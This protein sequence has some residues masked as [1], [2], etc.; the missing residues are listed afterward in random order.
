MDNLQEQVKSFKFYAVRNKFGKWFRG[1]GGYGETWVDELNQA[2]IYNKLRSARIQISYFANNYTKYGLPDLVEFSI[3]EIKVIDETQRVA[4]VKKKK[5][6][7]AE[8]KRLWH[9]QSEVE[10]AK[11]KF[12]EAKKKLKELEGE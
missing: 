4:D 7:A 1:C 10:D 5:E 6:I 9:H 8:K 12:E 2:R 3:G 11:K